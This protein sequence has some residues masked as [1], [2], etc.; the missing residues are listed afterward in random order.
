[1]RLRVDRERCCSSGM[2]VLAA[3]EIF[4]QDD[5]GQVVLLDPAPPPEHHDAARLAVQTCP[6]EAITEYIS[7]AA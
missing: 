6:G 4:D 2:C 3:P 7:P 1:M 5:D